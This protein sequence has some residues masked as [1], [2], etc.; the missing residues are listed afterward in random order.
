VF[1]LKL[2]KMLVM[3]LKPLVA[4]KGE[5]RV[6]VFLVR[7]GMSR[8]RA[9]MVASGRKMR[10]MRD[11]TVREL[12]EIL[13]VMPN[14]LF[15][16]TGAADHHLAALN[17]A[18]L[19]ELEHVLMGKS[20]EEL[21]QMWKELTERV[22]DREPK[23]V[24]RG[25][26]VWLNVRRMMEQRSSAHPAQTL[27]RFGFSEMVSRTLT[28]VK[29]LDGQTYLKMPMLTKLCERLKCLPNDLYDFNGPEGHVLDGLRKRPVEGLDAL[30]KR[31]T[32][33][34][35]RRL[36]GGGGIG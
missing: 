22:A 9:N 23:Q 10:M 6:V 11:D 28:D 7:N 5:K 3:D 35:V 24:V 4:M 27:Q 14:D 19:R 8:A 20:G 31:M 12:C 18:P 26:R 30:V 25:G 2:N 13:E 29:R 36:L 1:H 21:E 17:K 34:E 15:S 16:W 33:E 32:A